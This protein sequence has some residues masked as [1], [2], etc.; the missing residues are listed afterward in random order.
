MKNLI[1]KKI[2]T[3]VPAKCPVCMKQCAAVFRNWKPTKRVS[4][5]FIHSEG[6][7]ICRKTYDYK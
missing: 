2:A 3:S 7:K 4:V 1:P 6:K 5:E